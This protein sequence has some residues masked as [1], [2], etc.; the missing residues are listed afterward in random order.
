MAQR[1]SHR[2]EEFSVSYAEQVGGII[3]SLVRK[4]FFFPRIPALF[5]V[6]RELPLGLDGSVFLSPN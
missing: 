5:K 6:E 3:I 2:K 4:V 1:S